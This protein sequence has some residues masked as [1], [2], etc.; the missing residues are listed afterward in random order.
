MY[1]GGIRTDVVDYQS[2]AQQVSV[3]IEGAGAREAEM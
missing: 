1:V 2:H 3:V